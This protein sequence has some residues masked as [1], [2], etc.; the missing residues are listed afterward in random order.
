MRFFS[1]PK[2]QAHDRMAKDKIMRITIVG[3]IFFVTENPLVNIMMNFFSR[4]CFDGAHGEYLGTVQMLEM[5]L[6]WSKS[7]HSVPKHC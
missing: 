5:F 7:T 2:F 4:Q 3:K 6:N 1:R